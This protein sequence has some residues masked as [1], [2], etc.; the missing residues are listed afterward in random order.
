MDAV[1]SGHIRIVVCQIGADQLEVRPLEPDIG[2]SVFVCMKAEVSRIHIQGLADPVDKGIGAFEMG[3]GQ[4]AHELTDLSRHDLEPGHVQSCLFAVKD[5]GP[6]HAVGRVERAGQVLWL[7]RND[8]SPVIPVHQIPAGI[9]A[10]APVPDVSLAVGLFLV[11][12]V[13]VPELFL[14]IPENG[15]TV[16]LNGLSRC[17]QPYPAGSNAFISHILTIIPAHT[18]ASLPLRFPFCRAA[19]RDFCTACRLTV[20]IFLF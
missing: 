1:V 5:M 14:F 6:V 17:V 18:H 20:L 15:K 7:G 12:S 2:L 16:G 13:P 8:Q 11:L 19:R 9:K 10:D 3:R 4:N